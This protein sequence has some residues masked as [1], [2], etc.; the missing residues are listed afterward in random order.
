VKGEPVYICP[1]EGSGGGIVGVMKV[2]GTLPQGKRWRESLRFS[3]K[4][5]GRGEVSFLEK[6]SI[7]LPS[8]GR[9]PFLFE[10]G[11]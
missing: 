6:E 11:P 7:I 10:G 3:L 1:Q 4:E 5:G 9:N 2:E 8:I